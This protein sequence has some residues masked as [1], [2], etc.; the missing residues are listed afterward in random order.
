MATNSE[1]SLKPLSVA[2][3]EYLGDRPVRMILWEIDEVSLWSRYEYAAREDEI[4]EA[5]EFW[6]WENLNR[7]FL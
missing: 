1:P 2:M 4:A 7:K 3:Q 6:T 5:A